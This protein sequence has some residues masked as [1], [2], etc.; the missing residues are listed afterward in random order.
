MDAVTE[1]AGVVKQAARV[2]ALEAQVTELRRKVE[3][4]VSTRET[5]GSDRMLTMR[6]VAERT[7]LSRATVY[8]LIAAGTFPRQIKVGEVAA[9]WSEAEV[10]RWIES[11]QA[12]R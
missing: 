7:G 11:R 10:E 2:P 12:D 6:E 4:L 1:F 9:R 8:R 3:A 5:A